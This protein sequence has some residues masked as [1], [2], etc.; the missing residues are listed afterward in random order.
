M[1]SMKTISA[2]WRKSWRCSEKRRARL[3]A[4][5]CE[6]LALI[7]RAAESKNREE[8]ERQEQEAERE[9]NALAEAFRQ[10]DEDDDVDDEVDQRNEHQDD[11]PDRLADD[12]QQD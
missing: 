11:P 7:L 12:F 10:L 6:T 3:R 8:D 5:P 4:G 9:A 1:R 2:G